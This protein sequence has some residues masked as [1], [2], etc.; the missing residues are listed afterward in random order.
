M[1]SGR[2]VDEMCRVIGFQTWVL[3]SVELTGHMQGNGSVCARE[4]QGIRRDGGM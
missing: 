2:G 3:L 1:E 4:A